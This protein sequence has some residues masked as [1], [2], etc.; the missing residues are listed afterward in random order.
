ME[1]IKV[2][3]PQAIWVNKSHIDP[4]IKHV[5]IE[6]WGLDTSIFWS[7]IHYPCHSFEMWDFD[8]CTDSNSYTNGLFPLNWTGISDAVSG[9]YSKSHVQDHAISKHLFPF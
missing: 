2:N 5:K 1:T 9:Q 3:I 7:L 4:L 6:I 8:L